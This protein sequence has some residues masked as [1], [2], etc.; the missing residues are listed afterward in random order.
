MAVL[1]KKT[2]TSRA[3]AFTSATI[4]RLASIDDQQLGEVAAGATTKSNNQYKT[5]IESD[6]ISGTSCR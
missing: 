3:L 5:H 4:R 6:P 1:M 2:T